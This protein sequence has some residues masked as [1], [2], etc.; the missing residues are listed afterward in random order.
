MESRSHHRSHHRRRSL[1]RSR[2]RSRSRSPARRRRLYSESPP[3]RRRRSRSPSGYRSR[4]S[5]PKSPDHHRPRKALPSQEE[6]YR[7]QR[8]DDSGI[9]AEKTPIKEKP[10]YKASGLL[11]AESNKVTV[12]SGFEAKDIA[13]KYHEPPEARKPSP[14]D[15]WQAYVFK[16]AS[17]D[18]IETI[19][20]HSRS[21]WLMGRELSVVDLPVE[22]PSCSKQHAVF[23]FRHTTKTNE[24][25]EK[26]SK[27][28]LYV[29]DL[30]SSNGTF[31]NNE[32][33]QPARYVECH[34]GDVVKFAESSREY[35]LLLPPRQ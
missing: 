16:G 14:S 28:G 1:S 5:R 12:G 19:Q 27:V 4:K 6:S 17:K 13:L 11:A 34:S 20:L 7:S 35:V 10:N 31:L 22:H 30:E 25:G 15:R 2:S 24:Y 9:A 26:K 23:Q 29:L 18:P 33:V 21:C 8:N 32:Q 3:R